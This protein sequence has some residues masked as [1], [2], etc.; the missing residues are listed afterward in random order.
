MKKI[1]LSLLVISTVLACRGPRG[2]P[3]DPGYNILGQTF[4]RQVNFAY[5]PQP[6]MFS[7]LIDIP[8]AVEVYDSDAILVYRLESVPAAGGGTIDTYSLIPQEFYLPEGTIT[9][10]YNHSLHDVE[11]IIDGNFYLGNLDP[12]FTNN[13]VFRFVVIPSD[14]AN[15]PDINIENYENLQSYGLDLQEF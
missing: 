3:G 4:E 14:W 1:I 15:D 2:Y 10:V 8:N 7:K 12:V 5:E 9:Y 13:Q 6:N 11:L